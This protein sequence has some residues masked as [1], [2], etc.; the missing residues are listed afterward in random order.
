MPRS[1]RSAYDILARK[2]E[3]HGSVEND[4]LC[5]NH[6]NMNWVSTARREKDNVSTFQLHTLLSNA[7]MRNEVHVVA[8]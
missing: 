6:E 8:S 4:E 5:N 2:L 7:S 3:S 1:G